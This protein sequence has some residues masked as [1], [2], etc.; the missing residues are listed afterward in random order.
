[1]HSTSNDLP[2][3]IWFDAEQRLR[4]S[5][6][7]EFDAMPVNIQDDLVAAYEVAFEVVAERLNNSTARNVTVVVGTGPF[8]GEAMRHVDRNTDIGAAL[9]VLEEILE[10]VRI[11]REPDCVTFDDGRYTD[12]VYVCD[13]MAFAVPHPD[14]GAAYIY[15]QERDA[16]GRE[17]GYRDAE[18]SVDAIDPDGLALDGAEDVVSSLGYQPLPGS[19]WFITDDVWG[20][21]VQK[22]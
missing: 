12:V 21:A 9:D 19:E 20:R 11:T 2:V 17:I 7:I 15:V 1:M 16:D 10:S 8:N 13:A 3:Y 18:W 6:F 4:D 5:E 14:I 22:V